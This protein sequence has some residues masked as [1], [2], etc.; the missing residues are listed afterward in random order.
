MRRVALA[1]PAVKPAIIVFTR[2]PLAGETKTRLIPRLG[3]RHAAALAD[4][5][6]RDA[7]RK[8][9]ATGL[10]LVIAGSAPQGVAGNRYFH[11]LAR[12]FDAG[13]IDQGKGSL[14]TRMRRVLAPYS[15]RGAILIG[16]DTPSLPVR[17]LAQAAALLRRSPVVFGP[18]LDGGYHLIGVRGTLP[19]IFRGIRWG[20]AQVL[21]A[22]IARLDAAGTRYALAEPWYDIDRW[23]DLMLLAAHLRI[24]GP[25][26]PDP[27]PATSRLLRRLGLLWSRG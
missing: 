14:G 27:C 3:A 11:A 10:P 12:R 7:L 4:A 16:T 6:T 2:E 24:S 25:R 13:L 1:A 9:R 15:A 26:A 5:F 22:T 17:C 19:D 8:A 18:S 21:A 23:S 20:R